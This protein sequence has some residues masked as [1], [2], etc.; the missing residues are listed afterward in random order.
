LA[1]VLANEAEVLARLGRSQESAILKQELLKL[2]SDLPPLWEYKVTPVHKPV[3]DAG[4]AAGEVLVELDGIHL[5]EWVYKNC[6]IAT[7]ENR[8]E[9]VLETEEQGEL[10]GHETGP[11]NTT[12]FLYGADAEALFLA[13]EPV[14]REYPLCQGAR[15]TIRQDA[16]QRLVVIA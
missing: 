6:D 4:K 5:P 10:D 15:V 16:A 7:L 13:I 8:L 12:L 14:L 1:E 11:E 9:A 2:Q 3:I